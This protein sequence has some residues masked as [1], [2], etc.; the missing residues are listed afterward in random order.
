MSRNR[1]RSFGSVR[2][3]G[4]GSFQTDRPG[5]GAGSVPPCKRMGY[6]NYLCCDVCRY[7][8]ASNFADAFL[9]SLSFDGELHGLH[10]LLCFAASAVVCASSRVMRRVLLWPV[11]I[12]SCVVR[13]LSV[14]C[15]SL[16]CCAAVI[17]MLGLR[18]AL[19]CAVDFVCCLCTAAACAFD[20][21]VPVLPVL[22]FLLSYGCCLYRFGVV[23]GCHSRCLCF[24]L[25]LRCGFRM[26]CCGVLMEAGFLR[27]G[28]A[29][30]MRGCASAG[31]LCLASARSP[32][33]SLFSSLFAFVYPLVLFLRLRSLR[34]SLRAAS[35]S[36]SHSSL[37][38][39]SLSFL[40]S[41]YL[42]ALFLADGFLPLTS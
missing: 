40:S 36:H 41:R 9:F 6:K 4:D 29:S 26:L 24:G 37:S 32:L 5:D 3:G 34:S 20:P 31:V 38:L 30:V 42:C 21:R 18:T 35:L 16:S 15:I 19:C 17:S 10:P 8:L 22:R 25:W 1:F 14:V 11:S 7:W 13:L 23:C 2:S 33:F 27:Y 28:L 39:S 12:S